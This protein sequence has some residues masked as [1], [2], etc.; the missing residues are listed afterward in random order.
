MDIG[1]KKN[2]ISD[3]AISIFHICD[4]K[5]RFIP[6]MGSNYIWFENYKML[7]SDLKK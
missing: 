3:F 2:C 6:V 7:I 5:K 4:K 1:Q